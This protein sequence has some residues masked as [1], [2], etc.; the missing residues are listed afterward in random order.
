MASK[1][2]VKKVKNG[3]KELLDAINSDTKVIISTLQ[4]FPRIYKDI[5]SEKLLI[6]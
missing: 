1:K 3:S 2:V 4:K 6:E 5:I